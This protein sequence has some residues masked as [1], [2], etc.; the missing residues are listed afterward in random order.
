ML[1]NGQRGAAMADLAAAIGLLSF[2]GILWAGTIR[3]AAATRCDLEVAAAANT[4]AKDACECLNDRLLSGLQLINSESLAN[5]TQDCINEA[6]PGGSFVGQTSWNQRIENTTT[7]TTTWGVGNQCSDTTYNVTFT[8]NTN[9][10]QADPF[11]YIDCN[12]AITSGP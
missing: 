7:N 5:A 10:G 8:G 9:G 6:Y 11:C 2:L 1:K 3:S 4:I 12:T